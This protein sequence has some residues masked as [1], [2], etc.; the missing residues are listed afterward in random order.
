MLLALLLGLADAGHVEAKGGAIVYTAPDG[1][2]TVLSSDPH[3][4][5]PV[6]SPDGT[7]V[8]YVHDESPPLTGAPSFGDE[9]L[10][11]LMLVDV[12]TGRSCRLI[13]PRPSDD[14][15]N[16]LR[17]LRAPLFSPDGRTLYIDAAEWVTSD[18]L[19]R[20]DAATGAESYVIDGSAE[21]VVARG[22]YAGWLLVGRHKYYKSKQ[23][24][25]YKSLD[26]VSPDGKRHFE[27]AGANG[28]DTEAAG[29]AW[30]KRNGG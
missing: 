11:A 29:A 16:Q 8:A 20:V 24:G 18:A 14:P 30:L 12:A 23:G 22:K 5:D 21:Q 15:R 2:T 10:G 7:R 1:K 25:S 3:D 6:L 9:P 19:H 26:A 13:G 4:R 28:E 17:G 27:I